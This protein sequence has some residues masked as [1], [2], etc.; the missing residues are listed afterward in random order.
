MDQAR[1][2]RNTS[3][4]EWFDA[5]LFA[6]TLVLVVLLLVV[7]TVN[8][9][10]VSMVPTLQD[11]EQLIVRGIFYTPKYGDIVVVDGY[12]NYGE[13]IVKRVI[14]MGGDLVDINFETGDVIVNGTILNE[15][16]ISDLTTRKFDV[17]FPLVVPE[18]TLFLLGDNRPYSK[19]SRHSEI[20]CIDERDILGEV[21]FRILPISAFGTVE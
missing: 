4:L 10:G 12:T 1:R 2:E 20:G 14:G 15:P 7:R 13:P 3:I 17:E 18:G 11:G 9:D 5:L 21:I 16:Y 6:L 19:D 8:V